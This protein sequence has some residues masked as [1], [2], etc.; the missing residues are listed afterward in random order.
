MLSKHRVIQNLTAVCEIQA[1]GRKL[2]SAVPKP[3]V[4]HVSIKTICI[5]R[6]VSDQKY[7][8]Q[9]LEAAGI[10]SICCCDSA[11]HFGVVPF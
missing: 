8:Q 6:D 3:T 2:C 4:L 10:V 1:N 5:S 7:C 9:L 11:A